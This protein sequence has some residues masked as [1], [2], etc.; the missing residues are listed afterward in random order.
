MKLFRNKKGDLS[1]SVNAIVILVLA[2]TMLGLGLSFIRTMFGKTTGKL[3]SVIEST[4]LE[5]KPTS[6]NPLTIQK[7]IELKLG[8]PKQIEIGFYNTESGTVYDVKPIIP[9][10]ACYKSDGTVIAQANNP[11]LAAIASTQV[12]SGDSA[13]FKATITLPAAN[14]LPGDTQLVC[15]IEISACKVKPTGTPATCANT[16]GTP[17]IVNAMTAETAQFFIKVVS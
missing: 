12:D 15:S 3:G 4:D 10:T 5:T 1:L 2:I 11:Q 17:P 9:T 8:E 16:P 7:Q 14:N 13:G 6:E